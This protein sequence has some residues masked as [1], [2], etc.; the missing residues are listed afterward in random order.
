[1]THVPLDPIASRLLQYGADIVGSSAGFA[2]EYFAKVPPGAGGPIAVFLAGALK[3]V[4]CRTLSS[5]E[6]ARIGGVSLHAIERI[7]ARI[8]SGHHLRSDGLFEESSGQRSP[9]AE[10]FEGILLKARDTYEE[11]KLRYLGFLFANLVFSA[12]V[13]Y[14]TAHLLIHH[15]ERLT[16]RQLC[17]LAVVAKHGVYDMEALRRPNHSDL[18]IVALKREEMDLH[19]NDLGTLGLLHGEGSWGDTLSILGTT[20]HDLASLEE[21]PAADIES[22]ERTIDKLRETLAAS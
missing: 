9:S 22:I 1:M 20:M 17:I 6:Q 2:L 19:G 3:E 15:Y 16:Y 10:L 5:R 7:S 12:N 13:S 18:E 21:I 11:K 8:L 4:G 14:T